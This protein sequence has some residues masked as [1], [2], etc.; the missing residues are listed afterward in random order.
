MI[1]PAELGTRG[2]ER[3][4]NPPSAIRN[5]QSLAP[6][7]LPPD[8]LIN[9]YSK[10]G[11]RYTSYPPVPYW[12]RPY[13]EEDYRRALQ[14]MDSW[15]RCG[16]GDSTVSVYVHVPFC[17]QR[18]VFCACN[19]VTSRAHAK[20]RA[21]V[22]RIGREMDLALGA[23]NNH[24]LKVLQ[25]HL[26]GGTPTWLPAQDLAELH[27]IIAQRFDLLPDREQSVEVDPRV[28]TREQLETLV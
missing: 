15:N 20:G 11:P 12:S 26:G 18:C 9:K 19:V 25:L 10:P 6:E 22:E 21:F 28:T 14:D 8:G 16:Q 5:P 7:V 23:A 2:A 4:I 3:G 24:R 13:G 1:S 17:E 27:R